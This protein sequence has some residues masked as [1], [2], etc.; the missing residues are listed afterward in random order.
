MEKKGSPHL[1]NNFVRT[2]PR[3]EMGEDLEA[4]QVNI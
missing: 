1:S 2:V 4:P 3:V